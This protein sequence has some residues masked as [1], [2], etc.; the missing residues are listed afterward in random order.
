MIDTAVPCFNLGSDTEIDPF[1]LIVC[2]DLVAVRSTC[3]VFAVAC[4]GVKYV[5]GA[6][7]GSFVTAGAGEAPVDFVGVG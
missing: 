2:V 1:A 5:L 3:R 4:T 7:L 6:T